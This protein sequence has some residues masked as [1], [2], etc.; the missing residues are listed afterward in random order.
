MTDADG[1]VEAGTPLG[2]LERHERRRLVTRTLVKIIAAQVALLAIY[3]VIPINPESGAGALV[4]MGVAVLAVV[5]LVVHLMRTVVAADHPE[6]RAAE[7]VGVAL[8]LLIV[9]FAI[10]YLAMSRAA[11]DT[12]TE[13][14]DRVGSLYFVI[15][16]VSTVGF[17]DI[18]ARTD[19]ARLVVTAQMVLDLVLLVGIVRVALLAARAGRRRQAPVELD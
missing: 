18:T 10:T 8:P 7:T 14:L 9:I 15:S 11:P 6:L 4:G 1:E 2:Q 12:F 3:F 13:P 19:I 5:V 17:G 16:M